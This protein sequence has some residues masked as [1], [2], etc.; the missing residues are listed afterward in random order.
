MV[1]GALES[2]TAGA[3]CAEAR[4]PS[5]EISWNKAKRHPRQ[6]ARKKS[7]A[8]AMNLSADWTRV[9]TNDTPS[10]RA[11]AAIA[12]DEVRANVVLF[13]G[14]DVSQGG[15][16]DTW[17]FDGA[18]WT[19]ADPPSRPSDRATN[20]LCWCPRS[21]R[22]VLVTGV[23]F[24]RTGGHN[25]LTGEPAWSKQNL[26]DTWIFDGEN[27]QELRR[28]QYPNY[29]H[30]AMATDLQSGHVIVSGGIAAGPKTLIGVF[31]LR[32]RRESPLVDDTWIFNGENWLE[33]DL[34]A[35]P[36]HRQF[37]AMSSCPD[38]RG[39]LLF[40]GHG[41]EGKPQHLGDTW[42]FDGENWQELGRSQYPNY[43]HQAMA[44]DLQSGHVIVSGGIAAGPKTLIGVFLLR[45]RRE[46]P[47]A[48]DTW[49]FDGENWQ[50][51]HPPISPSPRQGACIT[52][53][54]MKGKIVLFGGKDANGYLNDTWI[55]NLSG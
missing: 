22:L 27:W 2:H 21:E 4:E 34:K 50:E 5:L 42:I 36:S 6:R 47:L 48:D 55:L 8:I 37:A 3:Y 18:D 26:C 51:I 9:E 39:V 44:T 52:Y 38:E 23:R 40:G 54:S 35:R 12:F 25:P 31:L 46:S 10:P 14:F 13:G 53:D 19:E 20:N 11:S 49:I 16:S 15:H 33:L 24:S 45:D 29:V 43:V 7:I 1:I 30:Q 17:I 41:G 32:D 28:S